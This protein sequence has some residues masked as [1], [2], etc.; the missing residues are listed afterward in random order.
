MLR[1]AAPMAL[2]LAA[3]IFFSVVD[4]FFVGRLGASALAAMGFTFPVVFFVSSVAMGVG[5]GLT[6]V[7][8]RAI[9][10]G[11]RQRVRRLVTDG[12]I[13]ANLLVL[14]AALAGLL[15]LEP[16]FRALGAPDD[17]LPLI[18]DYMVPLYLGIGLVVIPMVGNSAIRATGDTKTPSLVMAIAG[19]AN[20]VLDPLLIFGLGP[21]PRL[22]LQGAA[23]AT[24]GSYGITLVASLWIL[25][26]RERLLCFD[27]P[28]LTEML[29]SWRE[30]L[31]IG[32]P[33]AATNALV[34]LAGGIL[35]RLVAGFGPAAVAA[36]GVGTRIESLALIG[37][38]ATAI[39]LAPFVGQNF[40]A[41]RCDRVRAA[42]RFAVRAALGYG[43]AVAL[44]LALGA[45]TVAGW[46]SDSAEVA[47]FASAYL[48]WVPVS[49]GLFGAVLLASSTFNALGK[50]LRSTALVALRLFVLAVP[51]AWIG[52]RVFGVHG[53]FAGITA[54]N[55]IAGFAAIRAGRHFL[56]GVEDDPTCH[57]EDE[58][59]ATSLAETEAVSHSAA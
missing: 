4:T 45:R 39:A 17:L 50:P 9:G 48:W 5:V 20:V 19:G 47:T 32:V 35:T 59:T 16:L 57:A 23:L 49:Y 31:V 33:A 21:F 10:G 11:D 38:T 12:L 36:Y 43:L 13:L 53:L 44:L 18:A 14:L 3:V 46:F 34:P 24:V 2:G 56:R 15:T 7:V 1:L 54:A 58:A 30:I 55:A 42:F 6:S 26:R 8:S 29:A 51:L 40:G 37:I 52:G 41:D 25:G 28:R 27:R 22:E